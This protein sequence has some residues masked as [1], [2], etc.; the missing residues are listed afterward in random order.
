MIRREDRLRA[1]ERL[2]VPPVATLSHATVIR[3]G[4]VVGAAQVVIGSFELRWAEPDGARA[5]D[6]PRHRPHVA[7]IDRTRTAQRPAEHLR[8]A[9]AAHRPGERAGHG[10][11]ADLSHAAGVRAVHQGTARR[12][13]GHADRVPDPGAQV[14]SRPFSARASRSGTSIP[15]LGE[16]QEALA[17]VEGG[18][19]QQS[20]VAAGT[21]PRRRVDDQP[22]RS[23]RRRST[24]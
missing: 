17:V 21:L 2:R 1:F 11:D 19:G 24:R 23:T 22:R 6:P 14:V 13:A 8:T 9:G 15:T 10:A 3:L 4:Q 12:S 7:G 5:D 16:H 18:A 20:A